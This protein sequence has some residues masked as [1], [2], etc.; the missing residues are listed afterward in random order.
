MS[1][2]MRGLMLTITVITF[3]PCCTADG[4]DVPVVT[5][6]EHQPLVSATKRLVEALTY[7]GS[8]LSDKD[9]A[10]LKAAWD[11]QK[12]T[13]SKKQIQAVLD[14]LCVAFVHIN[15]ESRVK[16][17]EGAAKKELMQHGW[18]TFLAKVHNEAGITAQLKPASPNALPVYERGRGARQRPR[19]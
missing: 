2:A 8:P 11:N 18:R 3:A 7:V 4:Q 6:V 13:Q 15:P 19:S 5:A 12:Q 10:A 14:K 16:V 1:K 9:S 17:A